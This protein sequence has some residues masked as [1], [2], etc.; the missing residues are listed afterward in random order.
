MYCMVAGSGY[1]GVRIN[2]KLNNT[3]NTFCPKSKDAAAFKVI[4]L[5]V[6]SLKNIAK[7]KC[8]LFA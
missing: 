3:N 7:I 6:C 4:S 1:E 5:F 2:T 8:F